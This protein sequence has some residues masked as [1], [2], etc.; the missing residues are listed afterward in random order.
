MDE[1]NN[2]KIAVLIDAENISY[3][4]A[5]LALD[6]AARFGTVICKRIYADWSGSVS[7]SWRKVVQDYSIH[8]IQQF[9][10]VAGKNASDSAM[11]IDAMD[12]LHE[13]RLQGFCLVS[14]DSDF[15][16]LAS[17]LRESEML[18]VGMGE[19][20]TPSSFINACDKFLYMD[21]L[22]KEQK[23]ETSLMG[24]PSADQPEKAKSAATGGESRTPEQ[25]GILLK[26]GM[27]KEAI[28]K[29]ISELIE[30][31]SDDD[32]WYF[33]GALGSRLLGQYPDFDTRNFG[34]SKLTAFVES[35]GLYDFR[36][37]PL[38]SNPQVKHVYVRK[39]SGQAGQS[40]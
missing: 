16:R 36:S 37:D 13:G 39:K 38:P 4:Y 18:V 22:L 12:L 29:T 5:K 11:I 14:S 27:N 34:F 25:D 21:I 33:M 17:R 23:K 15:T 3:K 20:K 19:Q 32:G 30:E 26:P 9:S 40:L 8:P 7:T 6:E 24:K 10:T 31:N 1:E 28:I 35:I 2:R